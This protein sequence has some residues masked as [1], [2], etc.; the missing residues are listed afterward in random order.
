[1]QKIKNKFAHSKAWTI[2]FSIFMAGLIFSFIQVGLRPETRLE[3]C[4][5][6]E[7]HDGELLSSY[8]NPDGNFIIKVIKPNCG[9][10]TYWG[11]IYDC[12]VRLDLEID[13][14]I[15]RGSDIGNEC[16]AHINWLSS[17]EFEIITPSG[18]KIVS[19]TIDA[20]GIL[21]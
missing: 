15:I 5:L 13:Q 14:R 21:P 11:T 20:F 6:I 19:N 9:Q 16:N 12:S 3:L 4:W 8:P 2:G 17:W 7:G 18:K 10:S 1:M